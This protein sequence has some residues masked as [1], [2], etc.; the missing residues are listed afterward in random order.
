MVKGIT[1]NNVGNTPGVTD[2]QFQLNLDGQQITQRVAGSGFGQPKVS[3]EAI[4]EFQIV[5]N[6]FDI[7]QG[8]STGMQVQA[9]SRSGTNDL[10]GVDLRVLPQRH[11]STR[12]TRSP[13]RCC[14]S[15][16]SRS[17]ARWAARSCGPRCTSSASY[18]YERQPRDGVP[19]ADAA[20]EPDRSQFETKDV[21]KNYLAA[22]TIRCRRANTFTVRGQ[23]WEF[24]NPF[25]ISSGTAHP[26]TAEQLRSV[27]DQ[28]LSA[29]G[30][31]SINQPDDAA[32][33]RLQRLLLVQRR[34][35]VER[36]CSSTTRRS[37]CRSS[38]SPA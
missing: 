27:R 23:R 38:S 22:S 7:T 26:S 21:N 8:R 1:A 18:E 28:R 31:T 32:A 6:M 2:D 20:A 9:I 13:A 25:Q 24:D 35:P 16:T 11:A 30:R 12:P 5:T 36:T 37:T 15:R 10:R 19:G 34:D 4:A 17:A 33:R 3:R 29:P 14:R